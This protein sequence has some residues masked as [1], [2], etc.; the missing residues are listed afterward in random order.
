MSAP[1]GGSAS[2]NVTRG[3]TEQ[4]IVARLVRKLFTIR[5]ADDLPALRKPSGFFASS[6]TAA[7]LQAQED[8]GNIGADNLPMYIES[9]TYG[10]IIIF[11]LKSTSAVSTDDLSAAVN[12]TYE[13]YTGGAGANSKQQEMLN[14]RTTEVYQTG[15]NAQAAQAAVA[16][17]DFSQFFTDMKAAEAVPISFKLKELK[18]GANGNF[19]SIFDSTSFDS[20]DNGKRPIGYEVTVALDKIVHTS[21]PCTG[22][23]IS[24]LLFSNYNGIPESVL[25]LWNFF[26]NPPE[27]HE[28]GF[29][30]SQVLQYTE[31]ARDAI[32]F[33]A[34][35]DASCREGLTSFGPSHVYPFNGI[36][37][38]KT[39]SEKILDNGVISD[40][41]VYFNITK[42]PVY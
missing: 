9:V 31:P 20:R 5:I 42:T 37:R 33:P 41:E 38:G 32:N 12:A 23:A 16:N 27:T 17:L 7:D 14:S 8:A 3:F 11:T 24:G 30:A 2:M 29:G 35:R 10:R 4:T 40:F 15:G 25:G 13:G 22:G 21:G 1:I 34:F 26:G 18:S 19:V 6:V 36:A 28:F 39:Y